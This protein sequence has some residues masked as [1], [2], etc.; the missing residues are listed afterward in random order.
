MRNT[1]RTNPLSDSF[2]SVFIFEKTYKKK[3]AP[4]R[5]FPILTA[6]ALPSA[7]ND[8]NYGLNIQPYH[9]AL[10]R[11]EAIDYTWQRGQSVTKI[12]S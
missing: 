5:P 3:G 2:D 11:C 10:L 7:V 4:Q 6:K 1:K 8:R 12:L 9:Q